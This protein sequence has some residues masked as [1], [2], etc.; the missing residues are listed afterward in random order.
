VAQLALDFGQSES[1]WGESGF[2]VARVCLS[3][4]T[5]GE[6][7]E[8]I[9]V[10]PPCVSVEELEAAV[11]SLHRQLDNVLAEGRQRFSRT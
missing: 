10:S 9:Y 3:G 4:W 2:P 6:S 7:A 8:R 5:A 1:G 11:S